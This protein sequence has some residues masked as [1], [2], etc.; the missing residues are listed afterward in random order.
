[1]NKYV[2]VVVCENPDD[3]DE[4]GIVSIYKEEIHR[5]YPL[6]CFHERN[7]DA[8]FKLGKEAGDAGGKKVKLVKY[9]RVE[10][11]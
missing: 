10:E 8:I 9:M 5:W 6:I 2:W 7:R 1:M 4:E 3:R 11:E